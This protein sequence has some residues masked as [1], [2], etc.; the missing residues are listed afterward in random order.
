V[1]EDWKRNVSFPLSSITLLTRLATHVTGISPSKRGYDLTSMHGISP[2][3][4]EA[5]DLDVVAISGSCPQAFPKNAEIPQAFAG[6]CRSPSSIP[7]CSQAFPISNSYVR[8][9]LSSLDARM[10]LIFSLAQNIACGSYDVGVR[11]L[12]LGNFAEAVG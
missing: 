10:V 9:Y 11:V 8:T 12:I 4:S 1:R 2:R 5:W 3:S 7:S 6:S